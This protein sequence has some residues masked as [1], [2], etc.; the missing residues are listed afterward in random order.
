MVNKTQNKTFMA[1]QQE[2]Q[3]RSQYSFL[4]EDMPELINE[5]ITG[6]DRVT[7]IT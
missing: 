7:D 1:L 6:I 4:R 2:M 3:E 5:S